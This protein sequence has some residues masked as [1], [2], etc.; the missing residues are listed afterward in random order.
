MG[1]EPAV[2]IRQVQRVGKPVGMLVVAFVA[3]EPSEAL[4][5]SLVVAVDT[6]F[7]FVCPFE[8]NSSLGGKQVHTLARMVKR[9]WKTGCCLVSWQKEGLENLVHST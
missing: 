3:S 9:S 5:A 6:A 2:H 7:P 4:E 1:I 8:E